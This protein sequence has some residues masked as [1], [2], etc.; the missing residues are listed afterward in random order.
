MKAMALEQIVI[1]PRVRS[2]VDNADVLSW[3][4]DHAAPEPV[5]AEM[6]ERLEPKEVDAG[7]WCR[8]MCCS[9]TVVAEASECI[10]RR[11]EHG[12]EPDTAHNEDEATDFGSGRP[13][14]N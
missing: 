5:L 8:R 11:V 13:G 6:A 10:L 12:V 2:L 9:M 1:T 3:V 14:L 7:Q 4:G